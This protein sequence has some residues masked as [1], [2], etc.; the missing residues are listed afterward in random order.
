M[1]TRNLLLT[2]LM[3][4]LVVPAQAQLNLNKLGKQVKKAVENKV[5]QTMSEKKSEVTQSVVEEA[6]E[7]SIVP[8]KDTSSAGAAPDEGTPDSYLGVPIGQNVY[9]HY[10]KLDNGIYYMWGEALSH[11]WYKSAE[12]SL[13]WL[14]T[15]QWIFR[16]ALEASKDGIPM[17]FKDQGGHHVP[18]GEMGLNAYFA[19]FSARPDVAYPLFVIGRAYLKEIAN[20]NIND[21]IKDAN[22]VIATIREKDGE[23]ID[24]YT[25]SPY[26]QFGY[27]L[28][29][30]HIA[31][32][33]GRYKGDRVDRW[34]T[35]E[36]RLMEVYRKNVS[37]DK[38]RNSAL[39]QLVFMDGII[40]E[41]MWEV[42]TFNSY[43]FDIMVSD[44]KEHPDKKDDNDYNFI[45]NT[46]SQWRDN[47]YP[48]WR[49]ESQKSWREFYDNNQKLFKGVV[50]I[51]KAAISDPKLEAEMIEIAKTIYDDGRVPV[52]AIIKNPDWDYDRNALGQIIDRF[53]TAYII[54]KMPDGTHR[55]VDIG[56]KQMYNGG[57]YGKTQSRGIGL[58]NQVVEL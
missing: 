45:V 26:M 13:D 36:A 48:K 35:E 57:S 33:S 25:P 19:L 4:A 18:M 7:V 3:L 39:N 1:K 41:E 21:N 2:M 49:S 37:Y 24:Y 50:E 31:D 43:V 54:Y 56:F 27:G 58:V 11:Y 16:N 15:E 47:D 46:H 32:P 53:Q 22:V 12:E 20:G 23:A 17:A 30:A 38:V 44:L 55:M 14:L 40:K 8:D 28:H 34:K 10:N 5:E 42:L 6:D 51:P 52:K 9:D 29:D